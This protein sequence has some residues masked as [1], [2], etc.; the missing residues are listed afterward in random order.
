MKHCLLKTQMK[1]EKQMSLLAYT[2]LF[3]ECKWSL[4]S[5]E[6]LAPWE[7]YLASSAMHILIFYAYTMPTGMKFIVLLQ[8]EVYLCTDVLS[9]WRML[10]KYL[11]LRSAYSKGS[12]IRTSL[13]QLILGFIKLKDI[14]CAII[15]L[16]RNFLM[17][18]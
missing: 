15:L 8:F 4:Y 16:L 18:D 14:S 10:K 5:Q 17:R 13:K 12:N 9:I 7:T 6:S 3:G 11:Y 2:G 1:H